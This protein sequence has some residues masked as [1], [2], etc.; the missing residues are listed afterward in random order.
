MRRKTL[1]VGAFLL[2]LAAYTYLNPALTSPISSSLGSVSTDTVFSQNNVVPV[3]PQNFSYYKAN[4][5]KG[6]SLVVSLATNPGNVDVLLMNQGN[7]SL[8]SSNNG[9]SAATYPVSK[10]HVANYSFTF[11]N[12]ERSQV[13]FVVLV[14]HSVNETTEVLLS[15]TA[16]RPSQT[17]LLLFP[18]L[19]GFLGVVIFGYGL[20]GGGK[21]EK[22]AEKGK[23]TP[24]PTPKVDQTPRCK[25][26][27][28]TLK[29]GSQF[30]PNCGKSQ[31]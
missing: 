16:T 12:N 19:L 21:K 15:T 23:T 6:Y 10:L 20:G 5:T 8:W 29:P 17:A 14:S 25:I 28:S 22:Q 18:L 31:L 7:F 9:V 13:F 2:I 26:C 1:A 24:K 27:G 4:L 11:T 3:A 30:C